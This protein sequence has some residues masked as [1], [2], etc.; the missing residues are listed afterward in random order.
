MASTFEGRKLDVSPRWAGVLAIVALTVIL[1]AC[2]PVVTIETEGPAVETSLR[3]TPSRSGVLQTI[4]IP[5][6]QPRGAMEVVQ[7]DGSVFRIPPGHYPPPGSC[8]IW[9]PNR[10]PG[11][12]S[13]PGDCS[14]LDK[15]VPAEAYLVY[16]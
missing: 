7:A 12:Q 1:G 2:Y 6:P 4:R 16:G 14:V 15:R 8:R 10:S 13:P 9:F 11:Q 5:T 3:V